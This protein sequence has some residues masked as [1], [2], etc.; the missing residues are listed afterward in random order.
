[1]QINIVNEQ[2]DMNA[3]TAEHLINSA[4]QAVFAHLNIQ[5]EWEFDVL[6][7]DKQRIHELNK[8]FRDKDKP[9]DCL[10]FPDGDDGY[11]G[12]ICLCVPIALEQAQEYGHSPERELTFL[13]IHSL[14][15]L[16]GYDHEEDETEM[17]ALQKEII[18]TIQ[19]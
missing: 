18:K 5:T 10:S 6:L 9:T 7:C 15:H 17:F 8:D 14:L 12:D 11:L 4:A 2:T 16:L 19:L 3:E 13:T 1:M